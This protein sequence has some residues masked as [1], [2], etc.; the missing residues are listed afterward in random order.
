MQMPQGAWPGG[1]PGPQGAPPPAASGIQ[2]SNN[3]ASAWSEHVTEKDK[4]KY[5]YNKISQKS[6]FDKPGCL[7]TPE[8][9]SIPPCAW[10]EY[11]TAEG[12]KYYHNGT[13]TV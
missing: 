3:D 8:E 2:D 7:K 12:K 13:D 5:W 6:T 11:A 10:K 4:R 1:P 9:R